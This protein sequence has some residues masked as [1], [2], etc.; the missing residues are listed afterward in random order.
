V[1]VVN[2]LTYTDEYE[3]FVDRSPSERVGRMERMEGNGE[4]SRP[5]ISA[6]RGDVTFSS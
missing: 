2:E 3:C 6:Q 5:H 4:E 1:S